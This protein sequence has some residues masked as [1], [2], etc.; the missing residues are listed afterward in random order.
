MAAT[1]EQSPP[2]ASLDRI[3]K[4]AALLVILG[5]ASAAQILKDLDETQVG[6]VTTA[7]AQLPPLS[8][9]L[10]QQIL[11]EFSEVAIQASTA[12]RGGV[13]FAQRA[14]ERALGAS[15]AAE[16]MERISPGS[17]TKTAMQQVVEKEPRQIANAIK[18]EQPQTI[19]LV[20]SF[21]EPKK[22]GEVLGLLPPTTQ[23]E[24]VERLAKLAPTP[25]ESVE[26]V[27]RLV[28]KR[29]G[30]ANALTFQQSGGV[31]PAATL[32][33]V[34]KKEE[35]KALLTALENRS[36]DLTAAIRRKM[37]TFEDLVKFDAAAL[38]KVLREVDA[39]TLATALK[40]AS[41]TV[42]E[43]LLSALSKRAAESLTEEIG[44]LGKVKAKDIEAAQFATIEVVRRLEA[45]GQIELYDAETPDNG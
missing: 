27:G 21:L 7:M 1:L 4:L 15:R 30:P 44:F 25:V 16:F 28:L 43:R 42:K 8:P 45:E 31:Q 34:M 5:P 32:L 36:P 33:N 41:D 22:A 23:Q 12:L 20:V 17:G 38:Q 6:A 39:R 24:V 40:G 19:A 10:Q 37:F 3:Q 11:Q 29:T 26:I 14:L 35:S 13:A 2:A 9:A 18:R